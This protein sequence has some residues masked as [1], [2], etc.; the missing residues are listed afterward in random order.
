MPGARALAAAWIVGAVLTGC[1][2]VEI[3]ET[4]IVMGQVTDETGRPV[5]NTPVVILGRNLDLV[6]QR[7]EY[8]ERG[9]QEVK[10]NTDAEGRYRI[11]F[12]P[13]TIGNNF[14]MFFYDKTGF[15]RVKFRQPASLDITD[16]LGRDRILIVNQ[17]LRFQSGWTEVERQIAFYGSD[18][19][20]GQILRKHGLPDKREGSRTAEG[21]SEVWW[22][23]AD[24]VS[25]W[26]TGEKLT[27]THEFTPIPGAVPAR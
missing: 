11:E 26:F 16:L 17:V 3:R 15:D 9:R 7:L 19:E 22:Y 25:Y 24:G 1:A 12:V 21:N 20:R 23:Y 8:E 27:R 14:F 5:V 6:T 2:T 13:A 18:T 10:A 4:R